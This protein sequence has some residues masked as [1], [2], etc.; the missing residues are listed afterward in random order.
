M[1]TSSLQLVALAS[2]IHLA[3]ATGWSNAAPFSCP[4]NTDNHCNPQ[5]KSGWDF[6][7][8]PSGP[9]GSYSDFDFKGWS[10]KD[11][12][13]GGLKRDLISGRHFQDKCIA[14]VASPDKESCPSISCG[15][16]G[17]VDAFSV[18]DIQVS[19]EFDCQLEFHYGMGDGSICKQTSS[20]SKSGS[21]V[22]NKQCGGAK[23]VTVVYPTGGSNHGKKP[24]CSV[25]IHSVG[26]DCSTGSKTVPP[27]TTTVVGVSSQA[28]PTSVFTPTSVAA[29]STPV[30]SVGGVSSVPSAVSTPVSSVGGVSSIPSASVVSTAPV[31]SAPALSTPAFSSG[32]FFGNSSVP[33][34]VQYTTSTIFSTSVSTIISCAPTVTNCPAHSTILTTVIVP[35]STT[36]CPVTAAEGTSTGP[37]GSGPTPSGPAPSGP[38]GSG[39]SPSGS[40]P[41]G[42]AGSGPSSS[43][44]VSSSAAPVQYTTSTIFSTSVSTII[45]CAPTVTNC[46]AHSTILTTVVV[47]VST[48]ICPVTATEG[49]S[50][51]TPA[52]PA[53]SGP[54]PSGSFPSGPAASGPAGSGP[55][56]SG[57]FPSGPAPSGPA[58]SGPSPSGSFPSGPA[59]SGPAPSGAAPSGPVSSGL[60]SGAS[61][62]VSVPSGPAPSGS[63]PS[64]SGPAPSGPAGSGPA[65][66]SSAPVQYTTST[67][68]STSVSTII[69]C[70]P[71]VT[72]C[73]AHSTILTTV[74]VPVSTTICP[75]TAAEGASTSAPAGSAPTGS[76]PSGPAGSGPA[77]SGS[78]PSGSFPSGPTPSGPAG[79]GP[80]PSGPAP[81]GPTSSGLASGASS[82]VP[83]GPAPS[84]PA[85]SGPASVGSASSSAAPVQYTTSTIFST[86]V[87]TIISCAPTVTNCPAHSTILTTVVVPVST[88]IC[89]VT[90]AEGA[91][92]SAPAGPAPTGPAGSGPAPSATT[93]AGSAAPTA[94]CPGVL[95]Q[96]LN[97]WIH[98]TGCKDNTDSSCYCPSSD[99]VTSVYDCLSAHG[100]DADE[101]AAAQAYFQGICAP[102]V[103][104]NPAIVTA[105]STV[106][107]NGGTPTNVPVT[108]I[109]VY[110]TLVVPCTES[111]GPTATTTT[112]STALTVPQVQFSTVTAAGAASTPAVAL[113]PATTAAY[114]APAAYSTPV[115]T[116]PITSLASPAPYT[117]PAYVASGITTVAVPSS[118]VTVSIPSSVPTEQQTNG[119]S[120]STFNA[121][122]IGAIIMVALIAM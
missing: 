98:T 45:S 22:Q 60:A 76:S 28:T 49:A 89:P 78:S 52:G 88:T 105:A 85:G 10:C 1:K 58:G 111:N 67:I 14:G 38:A 65:P 122:A 36:V 120:R 115:S 106:S 114:V 8:L 27:A 54:T 56:P 72:N 87:S 94:Q 46:P 33:T 35:V 41:S 3:A 62:S 116:A 47:P 80:A 5:Q 104:S 90:A 53:G 6:S 101:V 61:S 112:I 40:L 15:G 9:F 18:T 51:S 50:T 11:S 96:C 17:Q 25:G 4:G 100:A 99:F 108:T 75:V 12:F 110:T 113:I 118:N 109:E 83:S 37:A 59:G 34:G 91:S 42:P 86:S 71:T 43:G 29:V 7:S 74:V 24:T 93:S 97:T 82:S 20:C 92:T 63:A 30:S 23:N 68:F 19:V 64:G 103:S 95:P 32:G 77:P 66:S 102:H 26:F 107:A 39:P 16:G 2:G 73:P 57:S 84:G 44:P 79:N 70:A 119:A 31:S 21:T 69:S 117:T 48:T 13:G 81:V 55:A 121:G